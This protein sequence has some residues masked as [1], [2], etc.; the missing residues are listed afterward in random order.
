MKL[1]DSGEHLAAIDS[2]KHNIQIHIELRESGMKIIQHPLF[3]LDREI[4]NDVISINRRPKYIIGLVRRKS[5]IVNLS[6]N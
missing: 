1:R 3:T 5:T 2:L 4:K 6:A